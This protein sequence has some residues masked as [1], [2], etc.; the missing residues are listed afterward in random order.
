MEYRNTFHDSEDLS[1]LREYCRE[2]GRVEHYARREVFLHAGAPADRMAYIDRGS[3]C[4]SFCGFDGRE[5][6][7]AYGFR[8]GFAVDYAALVRRLPGRFDLRAMEP[9]TLYVI[10]YEQF[11]RFAERD[12]YCAAVIR[13]LGD[14]LCFSLSERLLEFYS[15]TP[16][17]RYTLFL[18]RYPGLSEQL[19]MR[20][21]ASFVGVTPEALCRIRRRLLG[22]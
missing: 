4:Y 2:C 11:M 9:A 21:I 13:D 12:E 5:Y 7:G 15:C 1:L 16:E 19:S 20:E 8:G 3:I 18:D 22:R 14:G 10:D 17:E 6:T